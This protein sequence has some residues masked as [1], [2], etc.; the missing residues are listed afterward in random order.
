MLRF[1]YPNLLAALALLPVLA[2]I[3][4]SMLYWRRKKIKEIGTPSVVQDQ[5]LGF[6]PA[7]QSLKFVLLSTALLC[8]IIAAAHLQ[9]SGSNE[10]IQRKGVDV[11]IALDVSKSMLA[12][13]IQP[14]RLTR[15]KQFI[16]R[17]SD[18]MSSDR[19]GLVIFAGR[20]YVQVP[21]TVDYSA[22]KFLLQT[23][24]PEMVPT[25]GT[26]IGDAIALANKSF[27]SKERKFKSIIVLSDGEDH[28]ATA[29]EAVKKA[30]EE[31]VIVHTIGIGSPQGATLFDP[32]TNAPKLDE[33][34]KPIVSKL[35]ETE[36]K[37]IAAAG[38]GS[39]TLLANTE[40]AANKIIEA[41]SGMEQRNLGAVVYTN[42][43]S[44]FQYFLLAA[45]VLIIIEW[46]IAGARKTQPSNTTSKSIKSIS[47]LLLAIG[48]NDHASAQSALKKGNQLYDAGK[49]K[50]AA[51]EYGKALKQ[52][53]AQIQKSSY[54]LGNALYQQKQ[55][56]NA[57]KAYDVAAQK[58]K[59]VTEKANA[60]Y[61]T[62]NTYMSERKWEDAI[63]AYKKTLRNNPQDQDAKYN[64]SY[65]KAMLH[66]EQ[67]DKKNNKQKKDKKEEEKKDEKKKEEQQNQQGQQN[68]NQ[69]G[70]EESQNQESKISQQQAEQLL[71]AL[72]QEEKKLQE[73]KKKM[74]GAPTRMAKDW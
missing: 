74:H 26:V 63:E 21:L 1:Q 25:Q 69:S 56:D 53:T 18:K 50:E 60:Q 59:N 13:D 5:M 14:D 43:I 40:T 72:Q 35:N 27:S 22:L 54:N 55:I 2:A 24:N 17:L 28:D 57:R 67:Q 32:S 66:K 71:N 34:G 36:L 10:T 6:I 20:S 46:L 8:I 61:N 23:V 47:L 12:K 49:Y 58:A 68:Q 45:F 70:Q 4:I 51:N 9:K 38:N 37:N 31:G 11:M 64:L 16:S 52:D 62:G 39:Y 65:A 3:F 48:I 7:R 42:Y 41:L 30:S 15:A 33:Q 44:Y 19:V 73:Q 29:L